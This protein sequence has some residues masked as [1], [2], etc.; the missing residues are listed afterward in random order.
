MP[1]RTLQTAYALAVGG[2][3]VGP[4]PIS[5]A[6]AVW[7]HSS[8]I[9]QKLPP[10]ERPYA[11]CAPFHH[12][13]VLATTDMAA[14][15]DW[16]DRRRIHAR[17]KSWWIRSMVLYPSGLATS[18]RPRLARFQLLS[19]YSFNSSFSCEAALFMKLNFFS[20][21][22]AKWLH[23][24]LRNGYK[25]NAHPTFFFFFYFFL[26]PILSLPSHRLIR[27]FPQN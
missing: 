5:D 18:F 27:H 20:D 14:H 8:S 19:K 1:I 22:L 9:V 24:M 21:Y 23:S 17:S 15:G 25:S 16:E 26:L 11:Q 2:G 4:S 13:V 6:V 3:T 10:F 7:S 12:R